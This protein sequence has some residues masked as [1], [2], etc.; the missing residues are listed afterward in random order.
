MFPQLITGGSPVKLASALALSL[1]ASGCGQAPTLLSP[2]SP[3]PSIATTAAPGR[4]F[5]VAQTALFIH[6]PN[7]C[8]HDQPQGWVAIGGA[9]LAEFKFAP[10]PGARLYVIEVRLRETRAFVERFITEHS[11]SVHRSYPAGRYEARVAT[12]VCGGDG[13]SV[14]SAWDAFAIGGDGSGS[15]GSRPPA[16][17]GGGGDVIPPAIPPVDPPSG[18]PPAK[19]CRNGA[20]GDHNDDAH[21]DCGLGRR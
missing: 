5:E 15:G 19:D 11:W 1:L 20:D 4:G 17:S 8:P 9:P 18:Q 2:S 12:F 16:N 21:P 10:V 14:W 6:G 7:S 3:S 13:E